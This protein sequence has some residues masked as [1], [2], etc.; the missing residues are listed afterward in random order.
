MV[1]WQIAGVIIA[2]FALA[3]TLI[4]VLVKLN[5]TLTHVC[6]RLETHDNTLATIDERNR[7]EH[8]EIHAE[9]DE[10]YDELA[11]HETRITVLERS[12]K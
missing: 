8:K 9:L 7:E 6:D 5:V 11:D 12:D 10:H 3:V 1:G 4:G 2:G